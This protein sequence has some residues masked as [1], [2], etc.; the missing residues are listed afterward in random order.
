MRIYG[1]GHC[2]DRTEDV[3]TAFGWGE[4]PNFFPVGFHRV[5][6]QFRAPVMENKDF[7]IIAWPVE[8]FVPTIGLRI[9]NKHNG[10]VL[11]YTCDTSPTDS[12][13]ELA[14]GADLLL[15]EAAAFK[16]EFGHSTARQAGELATEVG[17][18]SLYLIHYQVWDV[19]PEPLVEEAQEVY[20]GPVVLCK[21][22]DR[23]E[24]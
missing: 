15:H 11:A 18:K 4:W 16:N 13:F 9:E 19:D 12:L 21:D 8:H 6:E 23:I 22:F 10:R 1:L 3:M 20:D 14:Q 24:L 5:Y 7:R 17:A 2:I